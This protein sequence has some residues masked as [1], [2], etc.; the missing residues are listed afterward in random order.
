MKWTGQKG[1]GWFA[2]K[3]VLWA[4]DADPDLNYVIAHCQHPT[5]NY[6]WYTYT[7]DGELRTFRLL[8]QAKEW[9]EDQIANAEVR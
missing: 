1:T 5:A 8:K 3:N 6:P 7:S 2:K 9:V 4:C